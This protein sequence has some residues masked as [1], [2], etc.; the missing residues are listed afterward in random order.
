MDYD[1]QKTKEDAAKTT[2]PEQAKA[3]KAPKAKK[4][5]AAARALVEFDVEE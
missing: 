1:T 2:D 3:L 4:N 5:K